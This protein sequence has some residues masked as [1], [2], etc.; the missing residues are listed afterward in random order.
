[1]AEDSERFKLPLKWKPGTDLMSKMMLSDSEIMRIVI[2]SLL[3]E[4]VPPDCYSVAPTDWADGSRSDMVY[5]STK[6][7]PILVE[8]QYQLNQEFM[9]RL[10]KYGSNVDKRYKALPSVLVIVTKSFSSAEFQDEFTASADDGPL[11]ETVYK[12]WAKKCFLL[13]AGAVSNHFQKATLN[14]MAALG[15][16]ITLHTMTQVPQ[17]HWRDPTLALVFRIVDN[18]LAKEDNDIILNSD[19][20]YFLNQVKRHLEEIIEDSKN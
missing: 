20:K 8:V 12:F 11:L 3:G 5:A 19:T 1:M 14:P 16:F 4:D 9:L 7:P 15:Y 17:Q 10:I 13:T 2:Q 18:I 6:S